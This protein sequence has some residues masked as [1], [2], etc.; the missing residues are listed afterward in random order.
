[1]INVGALKAA[2]FCCFILCLGFYIGR[3]SIL[4]NQQLNL[5]EPCEK[6]LAA[7]QSCKLVAV[8]DEVKPWG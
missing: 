2:Y 5:I 6:H 4:S 3:E 7:D 1:M 8:V